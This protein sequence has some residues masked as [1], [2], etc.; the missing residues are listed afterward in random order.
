M[1]SVVYILVCTNFSAGVFRR[2]PK[3]CGMNIT[4]LSD[5]LLLQKGFGYLPVLMTVYI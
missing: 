4:D 5:N 3:F 1:M 2:I